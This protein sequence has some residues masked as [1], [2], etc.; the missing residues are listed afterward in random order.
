MNYRLLHAWF[1]NIGEHGLSA[2]AGLRNVE[3]PVRVRLAKKTV[4][5]PLAF[6]QRLILDDDAGL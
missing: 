4:D 1:R 5:D 6:A 3:L 2:L